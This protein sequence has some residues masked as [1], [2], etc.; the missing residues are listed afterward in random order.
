MKAL[1]SGYQEQLK[2]IQSD[3]QN[4][5]AWE[6]LGDLLAEAGDTQRAQK[7]YRQVLALRPDDLEAQV[8][9][10]KLRQET[11]KAN[12]STANNLIT[13]LENW[14]AFSIPLWFQVFPG[15]FSFL[16]ILMLAVA[17]QW[18]VTDLV[19]SLWI[20]SLVLGYGYL[21]TGILSRALRGL[22]S[23]DD[24]WGKTLHAIVPEAEARWPLIAVG[25]L[26]TVAFF[27]V[28]FLMFHF[29]HSVFLNQFFPLYGDGNGF[30]RFLPIVGICIVRYWPV[31]VFSALTQLTSFLQVAESTGSNFLS[32][33][34]RNVVKMHISIFVFAGL[35]FA[36][37]SGL[38]LY[39]ML[40]LYFFPF[41]S[42]KT[43]LAGRKA[44]STIA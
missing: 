44:L 38:A 36:N 42:L 24:A 20:S 11:A 33:P 3:P 34:Y 31:V 7:C 40:I 13:E 22:D 35:S 4:A 6:A 15:L 2:L 43:L 27:S 9:L 41:G 16:A 37:I 26:F 29:V 21:L 28:H 32:M 8:G 18:Q 14:H 17:Q 12:Q 10:E 23:P 5:D 1:P 30:P 39:D 25:A 19:W